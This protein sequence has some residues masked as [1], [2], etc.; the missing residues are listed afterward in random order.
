MGGAPEIIRRADG[1]FELRNLDLEGLTPV[2]KVAL[3]VPL[4]ADVKATLEASG[5]YHERDAAAILAGR[6]GGA[7]GTYVDI[8][9][10][11]ANAVGVSLTSIS[12]VRGRLLQNEAIRERAAAGEFASFNDLQRALGKRLKSKLSEGRPS[13]VASDSVNFGRGDR[14]DDAIAP[15]QSYLRAWS[16]KDFAFTHINPKEAKR[17]LAAVEK[18]MENLTHVRGD[19]TKRSQ[20]ARLSLSSKGPRKENK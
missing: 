18:M 12:E 11:L 3:V 16:K 15:F 2:Q 1:S 5:E 10:A 9:R 13:K 20:V 4:W 6:P 7:I 14:F 17:R 19:L 8:D